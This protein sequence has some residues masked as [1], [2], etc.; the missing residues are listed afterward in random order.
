MKYPSGT[1]VKYTV[2]H[3][4]GRFDKGGRYVAEIRDIVE[5]SGIV[6][7]ETATFTHIYSFSGGV[8]KVKTKR[9]ERTAFPLAR[10]GMGWYHGSSIYSI[11]RPAA[12]EVEGRY[13]PTEEELFYAKQFAKWVKGEG[14]N[15]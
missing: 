1:L 13:V 3:F 8:Q 7:H 5:R 15:D 6:S 10:E 11:N 4:A 14:E 9:F 2:V 12:D